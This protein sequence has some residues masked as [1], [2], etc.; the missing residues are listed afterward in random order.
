MLS[1]KEAVDM[2]DVLIKAH[3][4]RALN[5]GAFRVSLVKALRDA[6]R[7]QEKRDVAALSAAQERLATALYEAQDACYAIAYNARKLEG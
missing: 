6:S 4:V 7:K 5:N 3:D 2:A 1:L